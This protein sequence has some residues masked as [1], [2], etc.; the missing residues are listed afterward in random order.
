[1]N[2]EEEQSPSID[3]IVVAM[4]DSFDDQTVHAKLFSIHRYEKQKV[5]KTMMT[6][7]FQTFTTW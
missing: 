5:M 4:R 3:Y 6:Q 7:S 1:M 2:G